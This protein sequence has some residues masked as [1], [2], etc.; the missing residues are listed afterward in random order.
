[1]AYSLPKYFD[2]N[3]GVWFGTTFA[4]FYSASNTVLVPCRRGLGDWSEF[5]DKFNPQ[6]DGR[7]L[8]SFSRPF[9]RQLAENDSTCTKELP[10]ASQS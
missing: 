9:T 2:R 10:A 1:M 4:A 3:V 6:V 5:S 8:L 7:T